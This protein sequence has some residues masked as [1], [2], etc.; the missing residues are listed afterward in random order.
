MYVHAYYIMQAEKTHINNGN[1]KCISN[2]VFCRYRF[3]CECVNLRE[4][5]RDDPKH[6]P[7]KVW[8]RGERVQYILH[9]YCTYYINC[10]YKKCKCA[11]HIKW[12]VGGNQAVA[13]GEAKGGDAQSSRMQGCKHRATPTSAPKLPKNATDD[14]RWSRKTVCNA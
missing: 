2:F 3:L 6:D 1:M 5:E 12:W 13:E 11:W 8:A 7:L 10:K 9:I 14:W 4:R